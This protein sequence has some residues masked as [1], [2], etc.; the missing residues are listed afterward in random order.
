MES[1]VD[2]PLVPF[3]QA[4]Q[5]ERPDTLVA[6]LVEGRV[7]ILVDGAPSAI[8]IPAA[9]LDFFQTADDF[10]LHPLFATVA[11]WLRYLAAFM[12]STITALF[13]AVV[14]FHYEIIPSRLIISLARTRASVPLPAIITALIMEGTVELLREATVRLPANVGQVIG[15]VGALVIGQAAVQ[16]N[17]VSH[18]LV[19]VVALST[20]AAFALPDNNQAT[21]L[22][23][24]R[25]P[26]I[27]AAGFV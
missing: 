27:I 11:R 26:L 16:A 12:S 23:L 3:P 7:C 17:L 10:Y 18:L 24:L 9:F 14:T 1:I 13:V 22:R 6:H 25:F 20:I 8:V 21:I 5:T 4:L 19:I 2:H 15:V